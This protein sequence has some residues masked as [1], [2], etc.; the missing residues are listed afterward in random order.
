MT[1][2]QWLTQLNRIANGCSYLEYLTFE[3]DA[4]NMAISIINKLKNEKN[5][6]GI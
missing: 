3:L 1:Y 6:Y 4:K 5:D 2:L